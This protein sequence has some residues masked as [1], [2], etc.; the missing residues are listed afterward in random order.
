MSRTSTTEAVRQGWVRCPHCRARQSVSDDATL[1]CTGCGLSY[2]ITGDD[3]PL[4]AVPSVEDGT[5]E[6]QAFWSA[7][8]TEIDRSAVAL[9]ERRELVDMLDHL[10]RLFEHREHLA[11]REMPVTTLAGLRVLEIGCGAG[12]HSAL[13]NHRGAEVFALDL[14]PDRVVATA[15]K[16]D[17]LETPSFC[18]QGDARELP[19]PDGLFDIV[20]SNGVLH[21]SPDI[22]TSVREVHRVLKPGGRA[23][24]MLYARNSFLYR[25]VLLPVRGILQGKALRGPQWLG[26]VTEWMASRR[27][28]VSNPWTTVFSGRQVRELFAQFGELAIRKN[29]FT[30]DQV[31]VVGKVLGRV[32]GRWTGLNPAGVMLYGTPWRNETRFELWAGHHIGWGLNIAATKEIG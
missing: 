17:L 27:Q 12:A 16:L 26:E 2:P 32:A 22:E 31:P 1:V 15:H 7:L 19:F 28:T 21:H 8:Q 6:V 29:S 30:L 20:Y 11:V 9:V 3:I 13:F 14:T 5:T 25:G 24:I 23:V 18:L 10:Q 4:L